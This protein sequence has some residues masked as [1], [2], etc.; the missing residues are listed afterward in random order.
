MNTYTP[1]STYLSELQVLG[2]CILSAF[3][4][5]H[6][7]LLF[8]FAVI[9]IDFVRNEDKVTVCQVLVAF[10]LKDKL[11]GSFETFLSI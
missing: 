1:A 9:Y 4:G 3:L 6:Q 10:D 8:A 7:P 2:V 5:A 11:L